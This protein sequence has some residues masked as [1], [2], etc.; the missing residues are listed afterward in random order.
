M[1]TATLTDG[2]WP[3]SA[4]KGRCDP[5]L[6]VGSS[7]VTPFQSFRILASYYDF[8]PVVSATHIAEAITGARLVVVQN[9]GY[10]S[11]IDAPDEVHKAID[12]F[13]ASA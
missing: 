11:Y 7:L 6:A 10:F 9:F 3:I 8:V 5:T 13:F 4:I 1:W 2:S 12:E